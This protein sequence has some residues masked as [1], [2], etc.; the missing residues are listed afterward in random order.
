MKEN[1]KIGESKQRTKKLGKADRTGVCGLVNVS[2]GRD[3]PHLTYLE[4]V[5]TNRK[6]EIGE[7]NSFFLNGNK[8]GHDKKT[9]RYTI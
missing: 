2:M 5:K 1:K 8:K 9:W 3:N 6:R 7:N 4:G